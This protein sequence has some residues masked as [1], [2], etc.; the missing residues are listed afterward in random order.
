MPASPLSITK[1][2]YYFA[3]FWISWSAIH[4][5]V[6]QEWGYSF[7]ASWLDSAVCNILL[8]GMSLL[9]ITSLRYYLP[10]KESFTYLFLMCI[11]FALLWLGCA[12]L[13]LSYVADEFAVSTFNES[14]PI[15][16]AIA[17]LI[18]GCVI[19]ISVLGYTLEEQKEQD[20]RKNESE[21]IA[22]DAELYKLRQQLQPHFLF[23][24]L[25]SISALI[26][27]QPAEARKMI[28][29]LSDYLRSTLKKEEHLWVM[30][31]EE[32]QYLELYLSIE[33]VRFGHRLATE[34]RSDAS[35]QSMKL[36]AMLL[37][38]VVENAIKF[39]LYDTT[40]DITISIDAA[41]EGQMLIVTVKNPFDPEISQ[42]KKGTGFGLSS[43]Q[44]RLSL[45]FA[46]NDLLSTSTTGNIFITQVK[47]PQQ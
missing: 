38:P 5:W 4:A 19:L 7:E 1:Y 42:P 44:R 11:G 29:Q 25:N 28:Q 31:S 20:S 22:R 41:A 18:S 26:I 43:V 15:R 35:A 36:P 33:K 45:L 32:V 6:L 30:L 40:D 24:S 23:N 16:L 2:R 8:A 21:K 10:R 13:V 3:I 12:K 17:I 47:I 37:Q 9:I 14:L 46:R 34:I 27:S 39:G